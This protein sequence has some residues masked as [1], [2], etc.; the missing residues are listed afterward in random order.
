MESGIFF[1]LMISSPFDRHKSFGGRNRR[2]L[3]FININSLMSFH[4]TWNLLYRIKVTFQ[5][6]QIFDGRNDISIMTSIKR[7]NSKYITSVITAIRL[8][9]YCC[10][11]YDHLKTR[12]FSSI[13]IE[14]YSLFTI[15]LSCGN[16]LGTSSVQRHVGSCSVSS[17]PFLLVNI[18]V[19]TYSPSCSQPVNDILPGPWGRLFLKFPWYV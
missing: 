9:R 3:T 15:C 17:I 8:Q 6:N 19:I 16:S 10:V 12:S 5:C 11:V 1:S 4:T 7:I 13:L 18:S 14:S 2:I